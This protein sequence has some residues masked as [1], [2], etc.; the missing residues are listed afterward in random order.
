MALYDLM[1]KYLGVPLWTLIGPQVRTWVPL[2]GWT[3]SQSP[4]GMAEEAVQLS[5]KGYTWLKYHVDFFQNAVADYQA[6]FEELSK[7]GRSL[8]EE[9]VQAVQ[10]GIDNAA[11]ERHAGLRR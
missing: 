9:T 3:M 1:G 5:R 6:E 10:T 8:T 11:R 7:L 2:S 4:K